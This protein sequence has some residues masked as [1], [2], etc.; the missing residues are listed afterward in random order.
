MNTSFFKPNV[1]LLWSSTSIVLMV[2]VF[3][4]TLPSLLVATFGFGPGDP[5]IATKLSS[6]MSKHEEIGART[7]FMAHCILMV[8]RADYTDAALCSQFWIFTRQLDPIVAA[9][10]IKREFDRAH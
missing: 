6:M 5:E 1:P 2:L 10:H 4:F 7:Q 3:S 9:A 8:G